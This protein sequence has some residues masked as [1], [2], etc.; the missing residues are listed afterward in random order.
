MKQKFNVLLLGEVWD[1]LDMLDEKSRDKVLYNID[2]AKYVNDPELFKKL[3]D[4]IWEFRTKY[5]KTYYRLFAFWDK[6][7]RTDTLVV[8]THGIVKKTDK[9][10]KAE[11]E[12]AKKIMKQYFE[13]KSER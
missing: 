6:T 8:A 7:D 5:K 13:Q 2:K 4:L 3:D 1:L 12:N 10:P 9:I 11:I